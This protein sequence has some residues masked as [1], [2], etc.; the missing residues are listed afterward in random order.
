M[1][2]FPD[3]AFN[4]NSSKINLL[5]QDEGLLDEK[6]WNDFDHMLQYNN[7]KQALGE[8]LSMSICLGNKECQQNI[9]GS[10]PP[11]DFNIETLRLP[12]V[13]TPTVDLFPWYTKL[14]STIKLWSAEICITAMLFQLLIFFF[15]IIDFMFGNNPH[16]QISLLL[17]LIMF[18]A[19]GIFRCF[20]PHQR[21]P[22]PEPSPTQVNIQLQSLMS[23]LESQ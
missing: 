19:N 13:K 2:L 5:E 9:I 10:Q 14:T 21:H 17:R 12:E 3:F 11:F 4:F 20:F 18:C 8:S 1:T 15:T 16:N 6:E 22:P 23:E 7:L